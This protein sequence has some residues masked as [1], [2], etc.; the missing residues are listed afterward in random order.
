[1]A[2]LGRF[3]PLPPSLESLRSHFGTARYSATSVAAISGKEGGLCAAAARPLTG[4]LAIALR[5]P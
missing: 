3:A 1:M 5:Q 2:G 4:R